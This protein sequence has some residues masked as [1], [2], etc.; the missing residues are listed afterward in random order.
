VQH[1]VF[2]AKLAN[3]Q[4]LTLQVILAC[5]HDVVKWELQ[6]LGEPELWGNT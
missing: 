4:A 5:V 6:V 2:A 3:T 1:V